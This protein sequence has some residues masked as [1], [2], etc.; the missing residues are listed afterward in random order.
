[1]RDKKL[2]KIKDEVLVCQK[3]T[4][5]KDRIYPVIGEGNHRAK[6]MF[7][8]EAPG[9]NESKT[10]RPF[11]GASGKILNELLDSVNLKRED[12]YI[13]NL[14]KDRPPKNRDPKIEEINACFGY[15]ERQIKII[16]PKVICTLGRYSMQF[17]MQQFGLE[18]EIQPIGRIHGQVFQSKQLFKGLEIVSLYHPAVAVYNANMK[19]VLIK[20]FQ[21][22]KNFK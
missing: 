1:M 22:L 18:K 20:D 13:S 5:Y 15:L 6:I 12:V 7:V 2:E 8:G 16:N 21:V 9:L 14:L 3:C 10:G 11:C 19:S 17:L 4:L